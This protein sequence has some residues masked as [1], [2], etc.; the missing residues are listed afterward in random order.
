MRDAGGRYIWEYYTYEVQ[1]PYTWYI[2]EVKLENFDLV[3]IPAS[4]MTEEQL[5]MYSLYM[6]TL[7]NR[8][9]LFPSSPY[10]ELYYEN[11][12]EG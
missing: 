10:V 8:P 11:E 7:G 2:C 9:D 6:R 3:N 5:A 12:Y 1:V 4:V